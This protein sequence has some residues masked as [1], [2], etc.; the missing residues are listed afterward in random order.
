MWILKHWKVSLIIVLC[1]SL[2]ISISIQNNLRKKY[3]REKNNVE[4]LSSGIKFLKVKD[5][6]NAIRMKEL[7]F[8]VEE[9]KDRC[10]KDRETIESLKLKLKNVKED[11]KTVVKTEVQFK[12]TLIQV[13]PKNFILN[14]KNEWF[15]VNQKIDF[16]V[17]PPIVD[18][19][20]HNKDSISHILYRV[21][22]WKFLWWD[23]GTKC[24][25][26]YV[27][28]HNPYS[29]ITYSRWISLSKDKRL[30]KRE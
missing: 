30:R 28:S 3:E 10:E 6:E 5:N 23:I 18:F 1:A 9:Y 17:D 29:T 20:Y 22:K 7:Q 4:S 15:E 25:E 8:T 19:H 26:I 24:Y 14:K 27:I 2:Y 13:S 11:V 21:P 12:D 16:S